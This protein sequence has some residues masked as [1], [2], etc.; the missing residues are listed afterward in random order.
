VSA[1]S[2]HC[3]TCAD[4]ALPMRV[5]SVAADGAAVCD[6]GIQVLTDLVGPV[7]QGDRLLVHAGVAI[8]RLEA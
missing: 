6:A 2:F 8:A 3:V 5:E 1:E 4:E 7:A